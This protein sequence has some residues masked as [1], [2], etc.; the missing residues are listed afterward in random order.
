MQYMMHG[1]EPGLYMEIYLPKRAIYQPL[2]SDVLT[3]GFEMEHVKDHFLCPEKRRRILNL[4]GRNP[5][6]SWFHD[7]DAFITKLRPFFFG[8][9]MYEV[10]GVFKGSHAP[11]SIIEE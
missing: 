9:S 10:D 6:W 1:Y 5:S 2:L 4:I 11:E 8:Y 3:K 7:Y